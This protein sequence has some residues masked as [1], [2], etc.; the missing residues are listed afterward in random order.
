MYCGGGASC[1]I[2]EEEER[3]IR[4][5][6]RWGGECDALRQAGGGGAFA[7]IERRRTTTHTSSCRVGW[8]TGGP[9]GVHSLNVADER[10]GRHNTARL[11]TVSH[12]RLSRVS[13]RRV[14]GDGGDGD[15]AHSK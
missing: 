12:L 15:V 6:W 9:G 3:R 5:A 14:W 4:V 7:A 8:P 1:V 2:Q 13:A 11:T 10:R